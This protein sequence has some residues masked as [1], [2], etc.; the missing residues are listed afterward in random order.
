VRGVSDGPADKLPDDIGNWVTTTGSARA[1]R[2][3]GWLARH[4]QWTG[5]TMRVRGNSVVA[6]REVARIV[7]DLV[8]EDGERR[9]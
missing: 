8:A 6:L 7:R 9:E 1:L 2:A 3:A 4:P 5:S